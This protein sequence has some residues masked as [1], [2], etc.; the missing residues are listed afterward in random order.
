MGISPAKPA[1]GRSAGKLT[2]RHVQFIAIGGAIGSGLFLGSSDGIHTAGPALLFAYLLTGTVVFFIARALGQMA[3]E[4]PRDGS[5]TTYAQEYFGPGCGFVTGWV[6]WLS[7][8][9]VGMADLTAVGLF[10]HFWFPGLPQWIP[11]LVSLAGL[12]AINRLGVRSFGEVEFWLA[13]VKILAIL[14][15][16]V[17]GLFLLLFRGQGGTGGGDGA[18]IG[19]A[20]LWRLGGLFPTGWSGFIAVLPVAFFAFGGVELVG[21]AAAETE[22]PRRS[23]PRAVNGLLLRIVIFYLGALAIIMALLP[24]TGV[25]P[26]I[27]PFVVVFDRIGIPGAAGL[28][29]VVVISAVLSSCNS[30][31]F[32]TGR[33]LRALALRGEAPRAFARLDAR[34]VPTAAVRVSMLALLGAVVLNYF[35][36]A[37]I[38]GL[39][40]IS[41]AV[42]LTWSWLM[43][44]ATHLRHR[45]RAV[46]LHHWQE[47]T[48]G[49]RFQMPLSPLSNY[50]AILFIIVVLGLMLRDEHLR[51]ATLLGLGWIAGLGLVYGLFVRRRA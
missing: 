5:F 16:I 29:N 2:S 39:L 36:P 7:W 47:G 9:I 26:G 28:V 23:L 8:I 20:N 31:L 6:Y 50:A 35:L 17:I 22:D 1:A 18:A 40:A 4:A 21:L 33:V 45:R 37:Q 38:F 25:V 10:M 48:P 34:G 46:H 42:L 27:S 30:G 24:W 3:L 14:A 43:I 12:Y 41:S 11:G 15:L 49:P 13:S 32:A 44:V 51:G 19:F